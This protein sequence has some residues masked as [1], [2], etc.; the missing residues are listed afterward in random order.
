M[1]STEQQQEDAK[2]ALAQLHR[3]NGEYGWDSGFYV[4][5][6]VSRTHGR[7]YMPIADVLALAHV[8]GY[9]ARIRVCR[10]TPGMY[11]VNFHPLPGV[12]PFKSIV[13]KHTHAP[14]DLEVRGD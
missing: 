4:P 6:S 14:R 12:R 3:T 9:S 11:R 10:R 1:S 5:K 2:E 7:E 13:G 8:A